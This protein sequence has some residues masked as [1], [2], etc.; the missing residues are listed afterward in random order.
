MGFPIQ[1]STDHSSVT[2]SLWLIAGSNVF[3]RLL[4]PSHPPHALIGLTTPTKRRGIRSPAKPTHQHNDKS[5]RA[6]H[7]LDCMNGSS[8][9][10]R[11]INLVSRR[12]AHQVQ[13]EQS[14]HTALG[15]LRSSIPALNATRYSTRPRLQDG[16]SVPRPTTQ[17]VSKGKDG[18]K[19]CPS[20][21]SFQRARN[22]PGSTRNISKP[23]S[24]GF[25][26][27]RPG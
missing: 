20:I 7:A 10:S 24:R 27:Q 12:T 17:Q 23:L 21:S 6:V 11:S 22:T 2:S 3:H 25:P 8:K 13:D 15:R 16:K 4:M 26:S 19:I 1:K 14:N 18:A 9:I 5:R